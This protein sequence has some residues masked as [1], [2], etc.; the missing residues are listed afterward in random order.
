MAL[1]GQSMDEG[2]LSTQGSAAR[3]PPPLA[4]ELAQLAV[5]AL[6]Y[7]LAAKLSLNLALVRGQVT[8]IWPST[9]IA[10]V[11]LLVLGRR[12]WPAIGIAAFAVNLPIGPSPVGAAVIA[13]GNT[14]APFVAAELLRWVDFRLELDRLRDAMALILI[15]ALCVMTISAT[16]GTS[17]LLLSGAI[18]GRDFW[19]TWAVWWAGDAM[20]VL[21]VAPFLLS[22]RPSRSSREFRWPRP[23]EFTALL[24]GIGFVT[25]VLFQNRFRVEYLVLPLIMVAAWRFRLR[26]AA[27]AALIASGVAIWAAVTG[28]GP[29]STET[30]LQKMVTLQVF[31]VS[32]AVASFLVASFVDAHEREE[33]LTRLYVSERLAGEANSAFLNMAA[34]ELRTP[35]SVLI[36]YLSMMSDGSLGPAPEKWRR[37]I[38]VL[39]VKSRELAKIVDALLEASRIGAQALPSNVGSIDLR[40]VIHDAIE[41]ARPRADLLGA[42]IVTGP[43]SDPVPVLGDAAQLGRVMDNLIN[44]GLTYSV[45][46]P[47]L[48]I[49]LSAGPRAAVVRIADNGV[50]IRATERERVFERF[51]RSND[52]ALHNVP[53]TGLGLYISRQLAEGHG[54]SLVV[55]SSAPDV[56]T[57]FALT[58]PRRA[59]VIAGAAQLQAEPRRDQPAK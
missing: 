28:I 22:L 55:A 7:W 20:G 36:G 43:M 16:I 49:T 46:P 34:H 30:L 37:P 56:G 6:A 40:N 53:G 39:M 58:I 25:Y 42:V 27:P 51:H 12:A 13:A 50:G 41:R 18:P 33:E 24:L 15:A 45:K 38:D 35:I 59:A 23:A 48:S 4:M 47:R 54:G 14:L 10:L 26:G 31:N 11:A 44:N 32:V 5:V 1:D 21:V 29:F 19:P 2:S 17:V 57:V 9:G 8:P 52:P 3:T